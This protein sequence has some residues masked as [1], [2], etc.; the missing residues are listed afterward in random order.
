MSKRT[1]VP[2]APGRSPP[3]SR[4][5]SVEV[6]YK[7]PPKKAQFRPKQSGNPKG[8]PKG[9]RNFATIVKSIM[10][11]KITIVE[12]GR[13]KSVRADELLLRSL[14]RLGVNNGNVKAAGYLLDLWAQ[15]QPPDAAARPKSLSEPDQ[16][17]MKNF[18]EQIASRARNKS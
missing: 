11:S 2:R 6:G 13:R 14:Y 9:S 8:R 15:V 1:R 5:R 10:T 7:K 12:S 17:I 3:S 16:D 18:I 4:E